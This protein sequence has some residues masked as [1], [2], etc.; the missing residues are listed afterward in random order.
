MKISPGTIDLSAMAWP[1]N[2]LGEALENLTRL[3]RFSLG[4]GASRSTLSPPPA[5]LDPDAFADWMNGA[6]ELLGI[7]AEPE[8]V[9]HARIRDTLR[10]I[11][12]CVIPVAPTE[13]PR[14]LVAASRGRRV[15]VAA[16]TGA[17]IAVSQNH[18]VSVL[19]DP[20]EAPRLAEIQ[21]LA[22]ACG[23]PDSQ[24]K[25]ATRALLDAH[26]AETPVGV[27]WHLSPS[28][29]VPLLHLIR[30]A[31]LLGRLGMMVGA[32]LAQHLLWILAWFL[33]ARAALQGRADSG[34]FVAWCLVLMT[35]V[36]LRASVTWS[37]GL[38][39]AGFGSLLKQRLLEGALRLPIDDTRRQG[40]GQFLG[41]VLE[42]EAVESLALSGG[43]LGLLSLIEMFVAGVVL[44]IGAGS[45]IQIACLLI[46]SALS[47][48]AAW[49]YLVARRAWS[50]GRIELTHDSVEH[51]VGHRTRLVQEAPEKRHEEEDR[52]LSR[53]LE[54]SSRMDRAATW[55]LAG[56]PGGWLLLGLL[57]LVPVFVS[58]AASPESLAIALGGILLA[59]QA[60]EKFAVGAWRLAG[61]AASWEQIAPLFHAGVRRSQTESTSHVEPLR[62]ETARDDGP[63]GAILQANDL[64]Y[65]YRPGAE[66]ILRDCKIRIAQGERWLLE[67]PSGS[68][69][70]TLAALLAGLRRPDAGLILSRGLDL[71]SLGATEWRRRVA[72]SPQFHENYVFTE[73]LAFNLLMGRRWPPRPE[74]L[75][76]AD[77][78]CRELGLGPL[79]EKMPSGLLQMV[80]ESGWQLSHG[81][82]SRLFIARAIL[83][84][85]DLVVLDE[86]F[87]ALDPESQRQGLA[88][89]SR[90]AASLLLIAQI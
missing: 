45:W 40:I 70:S 33:I 83:Q 5:S 50:S 48:W 90:R 3:R 2:R 56:I 74:D 69:K 15:K 28:S 4:H 71:P 59:L 68:G 75:E 25:R 36:P 85:A 38:L 65:R 14:Y 9:R 61:A 51:M 22:R 87:G 67:G 10:A 60:Y 37:E 41:R 47:A 34:W 78:V 58:G 84:R 89:V 20:I 86:S 81:E 17:I 54:A 26:L 31:G 77:V 76:E 80:G 82:L 16:P 44:G 8:S 55:L 7:D 35:L 18:L 21:E 57:G 30:R 62:P 52:A 64:V 23:L 39:A 46:W 79:L 6:A 24:R 73:T 88:C 1:R 29:R 72:L 49:S 12:V 63:A 32:Y 19:R 11:D 53:Y 43:I 27:W 66:P 42:S 13:E